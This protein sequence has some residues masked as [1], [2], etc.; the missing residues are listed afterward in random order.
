M[1]TSDNHVNEYARSSVYVARY[2]L[3]DG[4]DLLLARDLM[5][6]IAQSNCEEVAQAADLLKK[7]N[8][9]IAAK[10]HQDASSAA[11][12]PPSAGTRQPGA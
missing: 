1:A 9:A 2:H 6:E 5:E 7:I 3:Q 8:I 4:G 12:V 10:E 11:Q